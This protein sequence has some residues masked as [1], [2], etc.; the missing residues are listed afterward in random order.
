MRGYGSGT[1]PLLYDAV[2]RHRENEMTFKF[3][4][5][6]ELRIVEKERI[7]SNFNLHHIR[8]QSFSQLSLLNLSTFIKAN[9]NKL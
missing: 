1:D 4:S 5:S 2:K 6:E 8:S 7:R 3:K 9:E